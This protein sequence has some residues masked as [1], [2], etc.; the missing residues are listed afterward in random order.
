MWSLVALL[1]SLVPVEE[2]RPR[3]GA[4][5][6]RWSVG[7][8][9]LVPSAV[10]TPHASALGK[11]LSLGVGLTRQAV[12]QLVQERAFEVLGGELTCLPQDQRQRTGPLAS[13]VPSAVH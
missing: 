3:G 11:E 6:A 4:R 13:S 12:P 2:D 10:Q 7:P 1:R 8:G 9:F 5:P